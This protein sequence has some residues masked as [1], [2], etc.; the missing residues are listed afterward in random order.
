MKTPISLHPRILRLVS[1]VGVVL[2]LAIASAG[3]ASAD[4]APNPTVTTDRSD[5]GPLELVVITGEGFAP[6]STVTVRVTRPDGSIIK[7]DGTGAAGSDVVSTDEVGAFVY[8]YGLGGTAADG[9]QYSGQVGLYLVE[10]LDQN[11][12]V[13]ATTSFLDSH[14]RGVDAS[15]SIS[16]AGVVTLT[17]RTRWRKGVAPFPFAGVDSARFGLTALFC[18]FDSVT[19]SYFPPIG[20]RV[21][22]AA[23]GATVFTVPTN[24]FSLNGTTVATDTS[25]PS[26]NERTQ[27]LVIPLG[28]TPAAGQINSPLNR[29][30]GLY[31]IEWTDYNRVRGIRN[32]DTE[33]CAAAPDGRPYGFRVRA[34]FDGAANGGPAPASDVLPF[35]ARGQDY[36]ANLNVSDPDGDSIFYRLVTG[37]FSPTYG[38]ISLVPGLTV[39]QFGQLRIPASQTSGLLDNLFSEPA[40][41]YL[42]KVEIEDSRGSISV[43]DFLLDAVDTG[44][45][46]P[47]LDPIGNRVVQVGDT[48]AFSVSATDPDVLDTVT[49]SAV[50]LPAGSTF[51]PATGGFSWTPA[52]G[53]LGASS[54]LFAATDNGSPNLTDDEV[55]R[56]TV[57]GTNRSP[58]L[59]EIANKR[60]GFDPLNV[61]AFVA[62]TLTFDAVAVDPNNDPLTYSAPIFLDPDGVNRPARVSVLETTGGAGRQIGRYSVTPTAADIGVWQLTVR[63]DDGVGGFDAHLVFISV[64]TFTNQ[65]P[66]FTTP[67]PSTIFVT[68]GTVTSFSITA[69]DPDASDLVT[70][71]LVGQPAGSNFNPGAPG[72]PT[73]ASFS[74]TPTA[75]QIGTFPMSFTATDNGS[76]QI[77]EVIGTII[78]VVPQGTSGSPTILNLTPNFGPLI[79]G[80]SVTLHGSNFDSGMTVNL[81]GN[82]VIALG[83]SDPATATFSTPPGALGPVDV[84]V[85]TVL[86]TATLVGGFA[87]VTPPNQAP[88][89]DAGPPQPAVE[90]TGPSGASVTLDGSG[91]S[92]P[93]PGDVLTFAWSGPFPEGGGSI[94]GVSPVVTLALGG[95]HT[96]TLIVNDGTVNSL[97]DTVD[98]TVVDTTNPSLAQPPNIG[99]VEIDT[100][101]G[102]I[103]TFELPPASDLADAAP[104]VVCNP[105][106]PSVFA[107]GFTT[108][109]CTATDF[110]GNFSRVTFSVEVQDNTAPTLSQPGSIGPVEIETRAGTE[111]TY[112]NPTATDIADAAPTVVCNP[113][114]GDVFA[115]GVTTVTCRATDDSGNFSEVSFV[116]TVE[117]TTA[118]SLTQPGNIGPLE[119]E[120]RAGTVVTYANPTV[121][122]IADA[123]PTVVCNPPSGDVF[124]L[125]DGTVTCRAIDD[126]GNFSEVSFVVTVEDTTAPTLSPLPNIGPVEIETRAGTVVT[127]VNPTATDIADASPKVVCNPPS[128]D[129]FAL[130]DGTVTCRATD[131]SGNFSEVSFVVTVE[132][133]TAPTLSQPLD[134]GPVEIATFAGTAVTFSLPTATDIGDP[135]PTVVCGPP[136]GSV[137]S[138]GFTMV[139]C[140]A[141]DFVGNSSRVTFS[142]EVQ[143]TTAPIITCPPDLSV[144][145]APGFAGLFKDDPS[146]LPFLFGA[147][148]S[149]IADSNPFIDNDAPNF[150]P[151]GTT[152]VT[153]TAIDLSANT[154]TCAATLTVVDNEPPA[155][156]ITSA[157]DGDG[158]PVANGGATLSPAISVAFTG[159]DN[160]GVVGFGCSLDGSPFFTCTSPYGNIALSPGAHGL[161]VVAIDG[162]GN[163]DP[164]PASFS[165]TVLTP[166]DAIQTLLEAVEDL[167]APKGNRNALR[168]KVENAAASIAKGNV[169]AAINQLNAAIN[170]LEAQAGKRISEDDAE[171]LIVS[172]SRIIAAADASSLTVDGNTG[173][174]IYFPDVPGFSLTVPAGS[175]TFADG[176]D[177][178]VLTVTSVDR[179]PSPPLDLRLVIGL[180]PAGVTFDQPAAITYPN[181]DGLPPGAVLGLFSFDHDLGQFVTIGTGTVSE[182][183][184]LVVSDPGFGITK[185]G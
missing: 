141:T 137:F 15:A 151:L 38:P 185:G 95:P 20:L 125:G 128:G 6:N 107:L 24:A 167:D 154:A 86:G 119:I 132:D 46:P 178:G 146:L 52:A 155:T 100:P 127:Y 92:D 173:G 23:T 5:Y 41:D 166:A 59:E 50:G 134:I 118:P 28:T 110:V 103:V 163:Q 49:L 34:N 47:V 80:T 96:I 115:L 94:S 111:V 152:E 97:P 114:S 65:S 40:G 180:L 184:S 117:D 113:P 149:D 164:T 122:D 60:V 175:A 2:L 160:V 124:A 57:V 7:G 89:A 25:N 9:T 21:V 84:V 162:A 72:N 105:P 99:P 168:S 182:D 171:E 106:S 19:R 102:T 78:H 82:P 169:D 153:F 145:P 8:S 44:N 27:A 55:V 174:I 75:A 90:A 104:T 172:L 83:V 159:T 1:I 36:S 45:T 54:I 76:P 88:T 177:T 140:T 179:V 18:P 16:S 157:V 183:G 144:S 147:V 126:S 13:L 85:S 150:L 120:T 170:Y 156:T 71:G 14:N 135:A 39:N 116:V 130:G 176:S 31:D 112:A 42:V 32:L 11:G 37:Q 98:V 51:T 121:T 77:S 142:V 91:S 64:G 181:A 62:S 93:D 30:F 35:V 58:V 17:V 87:Y 138:L 165:W 139:E 12:N 66:V 129:V 3:D 74:W 143:D 108:V 79:G 4:G 68:E 26:F 73:S 123:A 70:L 81:G 48:V 148:A 33:S 43:R 136:S 158:A 63:V 53:D 56:V 29:A 22:S 101:A 10:V 161:D 133:N 131:D 61:Q 69:N 109:E 67:P